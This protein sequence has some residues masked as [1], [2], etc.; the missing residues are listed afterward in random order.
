[1]AAGFFGAI[2]AGENGHDVTILEASDSVLA[3]VRISGGGRCNVTHHCFDPSE[4]VQ[5]YPRGGKALRGPF[6]KFQ[7]SDTVAWFESRAVRIKTES[8]G[9]MFPTTDDSAT[10]VDCLTDAARDAGVVV[11]TRSNVA[12]SG[13]NIQPTSKLPEKRELAHADRVNLG[14]PSVPRGGR[15][16]KSAQSPHVPSSLVFSEFAHCV[17]LLATSAHRSN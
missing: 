7:P 3:K 11:R 17:R 14:R 6:A 15:V 2:A 5:S 9:R 16:A 13:Q 10:I 8:D 12:S 1:M 4:L